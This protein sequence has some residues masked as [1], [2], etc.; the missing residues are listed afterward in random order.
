M[1]E[2]L[3]AHHKRY[4]KMQLIDMV[5]L[6]YQSEF[7]GGHLITHGQHSIERLEAEYHKAAHCPSV[8][9]EDIGGGLCRLHLWHAAQAG[10]GAKTI[11]RLFAATA[12]AVHGSTASFL[13]KLDVLRKC[14]AS[15]ELP[16]DQNA[17]S[18]YLSDLEKQGWPPVSHSDAYRAAY[19]PAY[20]IV[21]KDYCSHV[22][23]FD[24]IEKRLYHNKPLTVAIDGPSGAGKST[25][26]ALLGE[27]YRCSVFHMDDFFLPKN[28]KTPERLAQ[29][30]GNIDHERF[31]EE[32]LIPLS[33]DQPF[34]YRAYDCQKD[35]L[36]AAVL[37]HPAPL[38]II[39]GVYSLHPALASSYDLK[40]F[41]DIDRETQL[42][43]IRERS[44][45]A[46]CK[47]F[48]DEWIPLE[49]HYFEALH[50]KQQS[51]IVYIA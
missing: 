51:D 45:E 49:D 41:I 35:A 21:K 27:V 34:D 43:R 23:A 2:L 36:G 5:K 15:G 32:V 30:G 26:A 48:V 47:R 12:Q 3:C 31:R 33:G 46:L 50:I 39:E 38:R 10:I 25:L 11:S 44:G 18:A 24:A 1:K 20:R 17:L 22:K 37:V 16:F 13:K 19:R 29:P 7:A 42:A 6:L 4:P 8:A 9:Y 28:R 14:C 40:I